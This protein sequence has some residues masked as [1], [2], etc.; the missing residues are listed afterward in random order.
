MG[1]SSEEE[2]KE[3]LKK[4]KGLLVEL[5]TEDLMWKAHLVADTHMKV[6]AEIDTA[7]AASERT[8][9]GRLREWLHEGQKRV[10]VSN[11]TGSFL[12]P[13]TL[14][15]VEEYIQTEFGVKNESDEWGLPEDYDWAKPDCM[16]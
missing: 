16:P 3:A 8:D 14:L 11:K 4:V 5:T 2:L 13:D 10:V 9:L 7:L 15:H 1:K 12:C 6:F